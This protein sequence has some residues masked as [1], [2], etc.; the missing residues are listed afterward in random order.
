MTV[1]AI[2][3]TVRGLHIGGEWTE[4]AGGQTFEDSD[5]FT[6]DVV[7]NVN[8]RGIFAGTIAG[9]ALIARK[10]QAAPGTDGNFLAFNTSA[11]EEPIRTSPWGEPVTA[12]MP[13][14]G[15]VDPKRESVSA[16]RSSSAS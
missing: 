1:S 11:S 2:E 7:A 13:T 14:N 5:P 6:G 12:S 10:G 4:A 16:A 15:N 8:E 3:K 9:V